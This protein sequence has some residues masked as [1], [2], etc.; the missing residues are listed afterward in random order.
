SGEVKPYAR[1]RREEGWLA[2]IGWRDFDAGT[3]HARTDPMMIM[4]ELGVALTNHHGIA[5][6]ED[7]IGVYVHECFHVFQRNF[8]GIRDAGKTHLSRG[9]TYTSVG[10]Y[11]YTLGDLVCRLLDVADEGWKTTV[12][13]RRRLLIG[14]V[15][16]ATE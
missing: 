9:I 12:F 14:A 7:W 10:N 4:Q 11:F 13:D 8:S 16:A 15:Q 1:I 6:T 5:S 2:R 3:R